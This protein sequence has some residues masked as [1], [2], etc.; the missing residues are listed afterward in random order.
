MRLNEPIKAQEYDETIHH[1]KNLN[2]KQKKGFDFVTKHIDSVEKAK[3]DAQ[4]NGN[5]D[6]PLEM[7]SPFRLQISGKGGTGKSFWLH[8]VAAYI[9]N[10]CQNK[11]MMKIMAPTGT[12]SFNINGQTIHSVLKIPIN[13]SKLKVGVTPFKKL[14]MINHTLFTFLESL[15]SDGW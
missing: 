15:P 13:Y 8:T 5:Q 14:I 10:H 3:A 11:Q 9:Q 6:E 2:E 7:P 1:P 4:A 12:A